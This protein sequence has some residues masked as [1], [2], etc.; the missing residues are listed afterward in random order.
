MA[1]IYSERLQVD[2]EI[3]PVS[4]ERID[5]SQ[6][7]PPTSLSDREAAIQKRM[8][9]LLKQERTGEVQ[10]S[11]RKVELLEQERTG[12][13]QESDREAAIQR[14]MDELLGKREPTEVVEK[15]KAELTMDDLN[16]NK[17]WID[18]A[19][20]I[21]E[22]EKGEKFSTEESGY[23]DIADWFKKRHADLGNSIWR[24]GS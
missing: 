21:Y 11:D 22:H 15:K 8:N 2:E 24:M 12:E 10:E 9:E 3:N 18:S 6:I 20:K 14:R 19:H 17:A 23:D 13:V 16:T 5:L 7:S 1:D 4:S